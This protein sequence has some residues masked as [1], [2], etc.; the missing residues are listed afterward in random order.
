MKWHFKSSQFFLFVVVVVVRPCHH[1]LFFFLFKLKTK[2]Q[3]MQSTFLCY[4]REWHSVRIR[5][6]FE[7]RIETKKKVLRKN[8]TTAATTRRWFGNER[9]SPISQR[10]YMVSSLLCRAYRWHCIIFHLRN[11]WTRAHR[12]FLLF[13][14]FS[15]CICLLNIFLAD[16]FGC[17]IFSVVVWV[18]FVVFVVSSLDVSGAVCDF[19]NLSM[20]TSRRVSNIYLCRFH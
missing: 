19:V 10:I 13:C 18:F 5:S 14:F 4:L 17:G 6:Y 15:V 12:F 16:D 9:K 3:L 2:N 20:V 7:Q 11:K 1:C 8:N